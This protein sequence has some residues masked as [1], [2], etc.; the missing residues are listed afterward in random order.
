[1]DGGR[2]DFHLSAAGQAAEEIDDSAAA[3]HGQRLFPGDGAAGGF[4]DGVGAALIF[5]EF[6]HSGD[7]VSGFV[8]VDGGGGA[9]A[10]GYFQR[11]SLGG[12]WR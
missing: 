11:S 4:D 2:L 12:R 1:M 8:D 7:E 10:F 3:H 9:E 5:G 6:F